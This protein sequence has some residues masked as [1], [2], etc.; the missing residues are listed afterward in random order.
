MFASL[1][2]TFTPSTI[3]SVLLVIGKLGATKFSA[4]IDVLHLLPENGTIERF[5]L[6]TQSSTTTFC[7]RGAKE[8]AREQIGLV[9][10]HVGDGETA[11]RFLDNIET[12]IRK[13]W[14]GSLSSSSAQLQTGS[15]EMTQ[16]VDDVLR[17][18]ALGAIHEREGRVRSM[19]A[20]QAFTQHGLVLT[21]QPGTPLVELSCQIDKAQLCRLLVL[22]MHHFSY[23][24]RPTRQPFLLFSEFGVETYVCC[25]SRSEWDN[26]RIRALQGKAPDVER[27]LVLERVQRG[28]NGVDNWDHPVLS[29]GDISD[30]NILGGPSTLA[31][32]GFLDWE[33]PAYFEYVVARLSGGHQP[34]W[35]RELLDMLRSVLRW[36]SD[37]M[38]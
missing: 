25:A 7:H 14:T 15:V 30:R 20:T 26:S 31:V 28:K 19:N 33:M 4:R 35:R 34:D 21:H 36:E 9:T 5:G 38:R 32:T 22:R 37:P 27:A 24:S 13:L 12:R 18:A 23:Y 2:N 1:I 10:L 11:D 16:L 29:H 17:P 8:Q 3:P 6:T